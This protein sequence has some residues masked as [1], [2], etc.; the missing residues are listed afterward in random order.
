MA[1]IQDV[2]MAV[3]LD[4]SD[5]VFK[6]R[7]DKEIFCQDFLRR[8]SDVSHSGEFNSVR[9]VCAN[10]SRDM[11]AV[12]V[13]ATSPVFRA[14]F[15]GTGWSTVCDEL[16][17]VMPDLSVDDLDV[18][19]K[20]LCIYQNAE[21]SPFGLTD[22]EGSLQSEMDAVARVMAVFC[23]EFKGSEDDP[24]DSML[25]FQDWAS[26][27][28]P[29]VGPTPAPFPRSSASLLKNSA[30]TGFSPT[31]NKE[32]EV[33][34]AIK[35]GVT[36]R[37]VGRPRKSAVK[38]EPY[39]KT[40]ILEP[41]RQE[42]SYSLR[43]KIKRKRFADEVSDPSDLDDEDE[44]DS[45]EESDV[46]FK[47]EEQDEE[48]EEDEEVE[49]DSEVTSTDEDED[50]DKEELEEHSFAI[51]LPADGGSELTSDDL[52]PQA[53]YVVKVDSD[54]S[55]EL[56]SRESGD[57]ED[58]VPFGLMCNACDFVSVHEQELAQHVESCQGSK[59]SSSLLKTA[60]ARNAKAT[61][62]LQCD[63]CAFTSASP[64][65][66]R[67]HRQEAHSRPGDGKKLG[68]RIKS[69][70]GKQKLC[71]SCGKRFKTSTGRKKHARRCG[72]SDAGAARSKVK[73][74]ECSAEFKRE[75][76][77]QAHALI[78]YGQVTCPI[79]QIL[80]KQESEVF[81]HVNVAA[82][83]AKIPKLQCCMCEKQVRN[84]FE[85]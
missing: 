46:D 44:D 40:E 26:S 22:A 76:D 57:L 4:T 9:I 25:L 20:H 73:C 37:R 56:I 81:Q 58:G 34:G 78:H 80:F 49:A 85:Q 18:F 48:E 50:G 67:T 38:E 45:D 51:Q 68:R 60:S 39:V 32:N 33:M 74:V 77:M 52:N 19:I 69:T 23:T 28:A 41:P 7:P 83:D 14:A 29:D 65:A 43:R 63:D 61:A 64:R 55:V 70:A 1:D 62:L 54:G 5:A 17:V 6:S 66:L 15:A 31:D 2:N 71:G 12:L 75:E 3:V 16:A 35:S 59:A 10:G 42:T 36:K 82:P 84:R 72:R 27:L 24:D 13:A 79:H 47:A 8:I 53:Y 30:L 11:P 21:D